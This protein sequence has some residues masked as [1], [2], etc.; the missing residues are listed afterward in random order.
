LLTPEPVL[1]RL[2]RDIAVEFLGRLIDGQYAPPGAFRARRGLESALA[3]PAIWEM[4]FIPAWLSRR[5][6]FTKSRR[7]CGEK[8]SRPT[9]IR[10]GRSQTRLGAELPLRRDRWRL[11]A[12]GSSAYL[13]RGSTRAQWRRPAYW[14]TTLM[15]FVVMSGS[16]GLAINV[17]AFIAWVSLRRLGS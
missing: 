17:M 2:D 5:L 12:M 4:I 14:V 1:A 8:S 15:G 13:L 7:P 16:L 10:P 3:R 6:A 9:S 11:L